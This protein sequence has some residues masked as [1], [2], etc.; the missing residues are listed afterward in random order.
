MKRNLCIIL[1]LCLGSLIGSVFESEAQDI[2]LLI[3]KLGDKEVFV[4]LNAADALGRIGQPAKEA[5]PALI[6]ALSYENERV[7][8]NAAFALK[9]IGTPEA[10]KAVAEYE[11]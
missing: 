10:M 11:Q 1:L 4:R 8:R 5:V 3:K 7:R 9:E 2:E 6:K